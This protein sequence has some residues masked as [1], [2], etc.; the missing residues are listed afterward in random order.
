MIT[1][2]EVSNNLPHTISFLIPGQPIKSATEKMLS[3]NRVGRVDGVF[4]T[5]FHTG[6]ACFLEGRVWEPGGEIFKS[7]S[8]DPQMAGIFK[9]KFYETASLVKDY[10]WETLQ[11]PG[12]VAV[13]EARFHISPQQKHIL[14][15]LYSQNGFREMWEANKL[16][17]LAHFVWA[18][19]EFSSDLAFYLPQVAEPVSVKSLMDQGKERTLEGNRKINSLD[20]Y[21]QMG[22]FLIWL[23]GYSTFHQTH[24]DRE[25]TN[26][27][28]APTSRPDIILLAPRSPNDTCLD[29]LGAGNI[30][31]VFS[32]CSLDFARM[33][34]E[35]MKTL[36]KV[37][38]L[39]LQ[40]EVE[41]S[42]IDMKCDFLKKSSSIHLI[43]DNNSYSSGLVEREE[44]KSDKMQDK[45]LAYS[46]LS[47]IGFIDKAC[48]YLQLP[49]NI[50]GRG[51]DLR[52]QSFLEQ[53]VN[54]LF[55]HSQFACSIL[56]VELGIIDKPYQLPPYYGLDVNTL[57]NAFPQL[58]FRPLRDIATQVHQAAQKITT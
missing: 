43:G 58:H 52:N 8:Q 17:S 46:V 33:P 38:T 56:A 53:A 41:L 39:V 25:S 42:L 44:A 51:A 14:E 47:L 31:D 9:N 19:I 48:A 24:T 32:R 15:K 28:S 23:Q 55:G 54:S 6:V 40:G 57:L 12:A 10:V 30:R 5:H 1:L 3:S 20:P 18:I 13:S 7:I 37:I 49:N 34:R 27:I 4:G 50:F 2:S 29:E 36:E 26:I 35:H 21:Q 11:I 45:K 22:D 16:S